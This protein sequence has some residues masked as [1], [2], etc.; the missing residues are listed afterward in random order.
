MDKKRQLR[1]RFLD[2]VTEQ[3]SCPQIHSSI[4]QELEEHILDRMEELESHGLSQEEA[5]EQAVRAMGDP[6]SIGTRLNEIHKLQ[7][8]SLLTVLTLILLLV[9]F[10]GTWYMRWT[11]EQH[12]GGFLYYVPGL[13][14]LAAVSWKG[15]PLLVSRSGFFLKLAGVLYLIQAAVLILF[16]NGVFLRIWSPVFSYF[17]ILFLAPVLVLLAFRLKQSGKKTLLLIWSLC[18]AG[19]WSLNIFS[20][21][22]TLPACA[23]SLLSLAATTACMT[24]KGYFQGKKSALLLITLAGFFFS[25][26]LI[27][28]S[29][30]ARERLQE[31]IQPDTHIQSV[32]DD[33][34]NS[35]LIREL[36]S[37]TPVT[38]GL[39]L[40][41]EE[42][43]D[44]GTG[45]W[46]F[47][48]ESPEAS[49]LPRY[50]DYDASTVTLWDILPQHYHNN[51]LIALC[52]FLFGWKGGILLLAAIAGFYLILF[53]SIQKIRGRLA[54]ALSLCCGLLLLFQSV[55]YI[56]GNFG[57]QYAAFP[58]LPLVSEGKISIICN[59]MLLGF[60]YSA[61]RYDR[62][63]EEPQLPLHSETAL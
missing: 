9:G 45:A 37:R 51:Y 18:A 15:Y 59:M 34:Y 6:I 47:S 23:F 62:V 54:S 63:I 57:Y 12:A 58:N 61:Y 53:V 31:F 3:I 10:A 7:K 29:A 48:K 33:T 22:L 5:E 56:L 36:L 41:P 39:E 26:C 17:S 44:Y 40:T 25:G 20:S 28:A 50:I 2:E 46:Y 30:G 21:W 55:F 4:R 8:A 19:I 42:M 27:N 11:P 43:M 1:S 24:G 60:I 16:M 13:L 14:T 32:W 52:I 38:H 35:A 49:P